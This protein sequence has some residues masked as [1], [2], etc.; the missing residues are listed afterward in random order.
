M[1]GRDLLPL[2]VHAGGLR[3]VDL[4]AIHAYV[5]LSGSR[6]ASNYARQGDETSGVFW[7]ALQNGKLIERKIV[8]ANDFFARSRGNCFRK[9]LPHLREHGQH[10]DFV[11]EALR[12]FDVH[13]LADAVGHFVQLV[14][15]KSEIHAACGAEL[16]DQDLRAGM[17]LDV[18]KQQ[19]WPAGRG[20]PASIIFAHA[21]GDFGDL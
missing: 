19:R 4:H 7:P 16:V 17:V 21:I 14:D 3:I 20:R 10:F 18:L 2:P 13:E 1:F 11:E 12:R 5:A 9:E 8:T 15:L 6:I